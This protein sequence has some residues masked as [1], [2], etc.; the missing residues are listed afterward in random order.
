M[1]KAT[2]QDIITRGV[3]QELRA[4]GWVEEQAERIWQEAQVGDKEGL[5][6]AINN[7]VAQAIQRTHAHTGGLF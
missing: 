7:L 1:T 6:W 3:P 4:D 2:F 5:A